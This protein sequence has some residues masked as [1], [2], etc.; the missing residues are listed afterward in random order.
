MQQ[1]RY[2]VAL[3][4]GDR[5]FGTI[6]AVSREVY[7]LDEQNDCHYDGSQQVY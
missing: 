2:V 5:C 4:T 1:S 7:G 3:E 6:D